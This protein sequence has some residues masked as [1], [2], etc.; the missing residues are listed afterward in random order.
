M[1]SDKSF[2]T[3]ITTNPSSKS[4]L[5]V[6]QQRQYGLSWVREESR[7][8][9]FSD[10]RG[11]T[12]AGQGSAGEAESAQ[13]EPQ[14]EGDL[15]LLRA[16]ELDAAM[17]QRCRSVISQHDD[18][19]QEQISTPKL[20]EFSEPEESLVSIASD[21]RTMLVREKSSSFWRPAHKINTFRG[22]DAVTWF[23]Q[24]QVCTAF[25]SL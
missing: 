12:I 16:A 21:L 18:M 2:G 22:C 13:R 23:V 8:P 9:L 1:P 10:S 20:I 15:R 5:E 24:S 6:S 25:T 14:R 7:P 3:S 11:E 19:H 4:S 17:S